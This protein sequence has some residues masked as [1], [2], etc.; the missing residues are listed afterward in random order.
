M[1]SISGKCYCGA[2]AF[3]VNAA[4][5]IVAYCHC[6]DCRRWTGAP[7]PAFAA[8]PAST[9][10]ADA[11]FGGG[12]TFPSG[13]TRWNCGTCGSPLAAIFPYLPDQIYLPLGILDQA[14]AW[15]P[16]RHSHSGSRLSW[17]NIADGLPLSE[18]SAREALRKASDS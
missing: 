17:V 11:E 7:Q 3:S 15:R 10:D 8:V 1:Q 9:L 2:V 18:G 14:S 4:P 6:E 12:R 16:E 5:E 13:V